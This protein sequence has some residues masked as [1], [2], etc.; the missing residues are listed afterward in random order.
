MIKK[1][2]KVINKTQVKKIIDKKWSEKVRSLGSCEVCGKEEWLNAHHI[3]GRQDL[4]VR[5]DIRNGCCLCSGCHTMNNYSAHGNPLFFMEWM[6][7]NR[8]EDLEYLKN[9]MKT[10][11][12]QYSVQDYLDME[13]NI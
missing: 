6:E 11:P 12:H 2:P 1:K 13:K 5:W 8:P 10:P 9:I 3:I 7:E 4:R